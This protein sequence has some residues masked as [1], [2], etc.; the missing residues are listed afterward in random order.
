MKIVLAFILAAVILVGCGS[1]SGGLDRAVSLRNMVLQSA[2]C[3]FE[4]VITADYGDKCYTFRMN[5]TSDASNNLFFT[6]LE[7]ETISGISG[8][9]TTDGGKLIFDETI[10]AFPTLADDQLTP[11]SAP[12]IFLNT[13]R[14]GYITACGIAEDGLR[15]L[16]N[17]TYEEESLSLD[18]RTDSNDVPQ[19]CEIF[20]NER[21]ILSVDIRNFHF[22]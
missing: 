21:R 9:F 5:C 1:G 18:I 6:V 16:I 2:G 22:L 20:W 15:I 12:W 11:V 8:K 10:L 14:A 7:P 3:A 13:L 19:F 4:A 17:D